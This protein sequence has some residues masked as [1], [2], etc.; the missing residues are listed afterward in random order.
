MDIRQFLRE[1]ANHKSFGVLL[2]RKHECW[3][4]FSEEPFTYETFNVKNYKKIYPGKYFKP[5]A[6]SGY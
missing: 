2:S 4:L 6:T 1:F 3:K 5:S